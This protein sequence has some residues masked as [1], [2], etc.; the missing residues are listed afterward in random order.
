MIFFMPTDTTLSDQLE[1]I[2]IYWDIENCMVPNGK[3]A[4]SIVK[5][6]RDKFLGG[7]KLIDFICVCDTSKLPI[8]VIDGLN[9]AEVSILQR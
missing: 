9:H 4:Q 8:T 5:K 6:I 2:G 7:R 3:S 1:P